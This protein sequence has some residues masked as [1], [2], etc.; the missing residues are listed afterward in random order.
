MS[1]ESEQAD[2]SLSAIFPALWE[3]GLYT[4]RGVLSEK[5]TFSKGKGRSTTFKASRVP[6]PANLLQEELKGVPGGKLLKTRR[7][8]GSF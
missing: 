2:S 1:Q 8:P 6:D 3:I 4:S 5:C 7:K